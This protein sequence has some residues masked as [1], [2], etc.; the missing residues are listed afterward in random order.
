M[1]RLSLLAPAGL[2]T[3]GL[4][5]PATAAAAKPARN[6][7]LNDIPVTG[8]LTG[9]APFAGTLDITQISR[10]GTTL[11]FGGALT[12][13]AT[14]ATQQFTGIVGTLASNQACDILTLDLGPLFLDLLGLQVDLDPVHLEVRAVPGAGN[15]LGNLLCAVA[16]LLDGPTGGGLGGLL[17]RLLDRINDLLNDLLG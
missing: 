13:T 11:L 16:G 2:L 10:D 3:V 8:T 4:T 12:N 17:D 14:G 15:L 7:L 1:K 6:A 9:G 5:L